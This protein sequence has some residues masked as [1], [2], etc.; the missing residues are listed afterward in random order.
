MIIIAHR[1]ASGYLPEHTLA[2]KAMAYALGADYLEQDVVLTADCQ[3]VVLHDIHLDTISDVAQRFPRRARADG[4]WYAIDFTWDELQEL[5]LT[6]RFDPQTRR[7]VYPTRFPANRSR[8]HIARLTEEIELIQGLNHSTG[9]DVG[10][11]PE[12]KRPAWHRE[13]GFDISQIVL[14]VLADYG[15][16]HRDDGIFLQCFDPQE[17]KRIRFDL[18]VKLKLVQLV[19]ENEWGESTADYAQMRTVGG[20]AAI[21]T[22]ADAIGPTLTH[23]LERTESGDVRPTPLTDWAHAA[24]LQVHPYTVRSDALPEFAASADH[25]IDLLERTGIDGIFTDFPDRAVRRLSDPRWKN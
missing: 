4:R 24:G 11:Y 9:G 2:S 19:G 6:E 15:Y 23:V 8:F 17:L 18:G 13:Q 10:L 7:P 14:H 12:I 25:L 21:A 5:R 16:R 1:G 22:Y 3:P 20:L